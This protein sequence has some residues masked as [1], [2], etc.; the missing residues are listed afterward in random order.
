MCLQVISP[1]EI[2]K[3]SLQGMAMISVHLVIRDKV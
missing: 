1:L 2:N 3:T